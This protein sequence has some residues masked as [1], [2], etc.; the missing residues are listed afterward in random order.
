MRA[1]LKQPLQQGRAVCCE[2]GLQTCNG[3]RPF[4][5]SRTRGRT[6]ARTYSRLSKAS[7]PEADR[8][9]VSVFENRMLEREHASSNT[10]LV[11]VSLFSSVWDSDPAQAVEGRQVGGLLI[12]LG[13]S[14]QI[15]TK[16]SMLAWHSVP[17][18]E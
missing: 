18:R 3:R 10:S 13:S 16:S 12:S 17:F 5:D 1:R 4:R 15:G 7:S 2:V 8:C 11:H 6:F 9:L 14:K